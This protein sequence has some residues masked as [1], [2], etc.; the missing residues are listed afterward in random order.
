MHTLIFYGGLLYILFT[1][2]EKDV[3]VTR[4]T[5]PCPLFWT[6]PIAT[7]C[8]TLNSHSILNLYGIL[9]ESKKISKLTSILIVF[10]SLRAKNTIGTPHKT[11]QTSAQRVSKSFVPPLV[12]KTQTKS[13]L[14]N[15]TFVASHSAI[16]SE[17][18]MPVKPLPSSIC[19][20]ETK[21]R[22]VSISSQEPR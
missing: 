19:R 12:Y 16:T 13:A 18:I 7:M 8:F 15:P 3:K 11:N 9:Y 4:Y 21:N 5:A 22:K 14:F 6:L 20:C 2:S 10:S 1:I 17:G